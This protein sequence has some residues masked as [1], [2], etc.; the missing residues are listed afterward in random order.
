MLIA[1]PTIIFAQ[2]GSGLDETLSPSP[3]Q[4]VIQDPE[5]YSLDS[6]GNPI[7][8]NSYFV[9]LRN[10]TF[11]S[12]DDDP[13]FAN[14]VQYTASNI[15]ENNAQVIPELQ[16][17]YEVEK[18]TIIY[19]KVEQYNGTETS[20]LAPLPAQGGHVDDVYSHAVRGFSVKGVKDIS[21]FVNDPDIAVVEP[22]PIRFLGTQ[23]TPFSYD[24]IDLD[25]TTTTAY[26]SDAVE[27]FPN[28]DVG[29]VDSRVL[30]SHPDLNV[31]RYQNF[32]ASDASTAAGS[33][34]THVAGTIAARD[35]LAGVVGVIPGAR[36][37]S[38]VIC[39][40]S[41]SGCLASSQL[42]AFDYITANA[43][44]IEVVNMSVGCAGG[45]FGQ[46][47]NCPSS[48]AEVNAITSATNA[49]VTVVVSAMNDRRNAQD[50]FSCDISSVICVS[51]M[52]DYDG[53]CGGLRPSLSFTKDGTI[54]TQADDSIAYF[55]NYGSVIDLMAPGYSIISTDLPSS[56][57]ITQTNAPFIG[58]SV[59][60]GYG[61]KSGTSMAAPHVA[62]AAAIVKLN[63]PSF[64]PAQILT[65]LQAKAYS[66]TQ[67]CDGSSKGGL[68][69][70]ANARSSEKIL[71]VQPY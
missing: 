45:T 44:S 14:P 48:V 35:N 69:T 32:L 33:H 65:D 59:H 50:I 27:N 55:S 51:A 10:E 39:P 67:A 15:P 22:I 29:V 57:T 41:G 70:G 46:P 6:N 5:T 43:A 1:Q 58:V 12:I 71:Y 56:T 52:A 18:G 7:L 16:H 30:A 53:K 20:S 3:E 11:A 17:E 2:A 64:T 13:K 42:A 61:T 4:F 38:L 54:Y 8:K 19:D 47:L 66:Q 21:V 31:F 23:Y 62:G 24:R 25:K 9:I 37:W 60:G 34:G 26:R 28:I 49:G 40:P 63:N 68:S 36:I